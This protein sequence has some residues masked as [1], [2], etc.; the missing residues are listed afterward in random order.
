MWASVIPGAHWGP[1]KGSFVCKRHLADSDV[2]RLHPYNLEDGTVKQI[3]LAHLRLRDNAV[4][5]TFNGAASYLLKVA[6]TPE[7][8]PAE[9]RQDVDNN[10]DK[11]N[12]F[13]K[14]DIICDYEDFVG[15]MKAKF[16]NVQ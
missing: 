8:D 6:P 1:T 5:S 11:R 15:N 16:D 7:S 12:E 2:F 3:P 4:S 10:Q 13:L 14:S 9:R